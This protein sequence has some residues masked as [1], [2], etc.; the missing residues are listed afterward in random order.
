VRQVAVG[1]AEPVGARLGD[2]LDDAAQRE[3]LVHTHGVE[4]RRVAEGDGSDRHAGD[5]G[6][7]GPDGVGPLVGDRHDTDRHGS[8]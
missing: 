5:A 3:R 6:A 8:A 7:I 4:Q 1:L 2:H